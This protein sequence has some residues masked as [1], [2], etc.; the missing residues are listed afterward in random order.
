MPYIRESVLGGL[1]AVSLALGAAAQAQ[2][3]VDIVAETGAFGTLI[4]AAQEAGLID[5]LIPQTSHA[6]LGGSKLA[7]S[8]LQGGVRVVGANVVPPTSRPTTA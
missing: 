6:T 1:V 8:G 3:N 7:T 4:T 5:L 2:D